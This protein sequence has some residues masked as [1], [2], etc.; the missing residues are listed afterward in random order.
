MYSDSLISVMLIAFSVYGYVSIYKTLKTSNVDGKC[1]FCLY[2]TI[3]G[4]SAGLAATWLISASGLGLLFWLYL[5]NLTITIV[6]LGVTMSKQKPN[7]PI[8]PFQFGEP[9]RQMQDQLLRRIYR[10]RI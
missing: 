2:L 10:R 8:S 5:H 7:R 1:V 6:D 9:D 3:L 4:Y